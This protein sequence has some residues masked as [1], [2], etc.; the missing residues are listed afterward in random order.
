MALM[1]PAW[2]PVALAVG[3]LAIRWYGIAYLLGFVL[4]WRYCLGLA[5]RFPSATVTPKAYDDFLLWV[6]LG[7]IVGGRLGYVLFYQLSFYSA[8]PLEILEVWHGGMSFHG[9]FLGF[10]IASLWFCRKHGVAILP[11]GDGLAAAAPIG[12]FFGRLANFVNGELWGR[13]TDVPWGMVFPG[14][15]DLP[16]HPS[17]LYHAALEGLLLFVLLAIAVRHPAVRRRP[18]AVIA[19]FLIGYALCRGFV[20]F[21]R[22]PDAQI[23]FLYGGVTMG[24]LLSLPLFF[25]GVVMLWR[26]WRRPLPDGPH[27]GRAS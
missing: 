25:A 20:E 16:R 15:G 24:Q 12:L 17:Q 1:F 21:F 8:A 6:V 11:F 2:D 27:H 14:A 10:L 9:G 19:L 22:E 18:G 4:G 5:A 3:P 13:V 7:V 23:G 26:V